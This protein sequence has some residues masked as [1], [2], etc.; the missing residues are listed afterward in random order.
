MSENGQ[1]LLQI[2]PKGLLGVLKGKYS[3]CTLE[4]EF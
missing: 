4:P 3:F 2:D 1:K